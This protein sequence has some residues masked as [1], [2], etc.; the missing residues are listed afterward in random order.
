MEQLLYLILLLPGFVIG[1]TIHEFAHAWTGWKLGDDTAQRQ[2]RLTLDPVVH[3]D[4]IGFLII[5]IAVLF[6]APLIGWAKPV[7]FNP[8]NLSNPR[9]DSV[10]IAVAGP[11]SNVLQAICW[12]IS[13][14]VFRVV[15]ER[16]GV[17]LSFEDVL[18][19]VMRNPD[20][21]SIPQIIAAIMSA[22]VLVN[23]GMAV[24][25]MIPLPPLDGHWILQG[26]GPPFIED[27]YNGIRQYSFMI[28]M[29]L[30][31]FKVLNPVL[32]PFFMAGYRAIFAV[33]GFP[34]IA[35]D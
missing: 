33:C 34:Q 12:L 19:V 5:V 11:I 30:I 18:N 3:I 2:G 4:P 9:R 1:L 17:G 35:L 23:I 24:F 29:A 10:L 14:L 31:Y 6:N 15:T 32:Q 13:L 25:N 16:M 28:L 7:P 8:H 21:G 20:V 26:L 27:F 22:G